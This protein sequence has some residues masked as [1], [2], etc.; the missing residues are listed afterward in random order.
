MTEPKGLGL[1][2]QGAPDTRVHLGGG[3]SSEAHTAPHVPARAQ[4]ARELGLEL[5][6]VDA[7]PEG[8]PSPPLG[9]S[10]GLPS[11]VQGTKRTPLA[12]KGA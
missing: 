10:L 5:A 6:G 7:G 4:A 2:S 9:T 8:T 11:S 3:Q 1:A 12:V